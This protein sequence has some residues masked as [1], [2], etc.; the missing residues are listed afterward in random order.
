MPA[1][2]TSGSRR[3]EPPDPLPA[4]QPNP[5]RQSA[6]PCQYVCAPAGVA[7][8]PVPLFHLKPSRIEAIEDWPWLDQEVLRTSRNRQVCMTCHFFRHHPGPNCIP[9]LTCQ[10][11]QRLIAHGEHLTHRCN[12]WTKDLHRQRGWGPE[13]A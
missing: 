6:S 8:V 3:S 7:L 9:L 5:S 10:L 2:C 12:S 4:R 1:A 13:V 11:H